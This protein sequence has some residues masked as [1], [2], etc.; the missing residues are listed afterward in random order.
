ISVFE[1]GNGLYI[2]VLKLISI[3]MIAV[4]RSPAINRS[5]SIKRNKFLGNATSWLALY[6]GF[7]LLCVAYTF[8]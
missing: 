1:R 2:F 5:R 7:P 4:A 3:P 8:Y 6:A